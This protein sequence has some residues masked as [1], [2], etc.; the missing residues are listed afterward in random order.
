MNRGIIHLQVYD[1]LKSSGKVCP[2]KLAVF[3]NEEAADQLYYMRYLP[4]AARPATA[5]YIVDNNLDGIVC[6]S[7]AFIVPEAP[8]S[9]IIKLA[10]LANQKSRQNYQTETPKLC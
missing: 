9:H 7:L 10:L 3:D 6:H 8:L 2:E 4:V 5:I 1:S